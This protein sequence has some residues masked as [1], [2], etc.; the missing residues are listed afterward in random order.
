MKAISLWQ[1]YASLI[2]TGAKKIETRSWNTNVRGTVAIHA[3][4]KKV[5]KEY[6]S[7]FLMSEFQR[8]MRP[9]LDVTHD[10]IRVVPNALPFGAIVGTVEITDCLPIEELYGG[11]YDT[12]N[13]RAFGDWSY[14][15]YGWKLANPVIFKDPLP[16]RGRQGF[17]NWE[18]W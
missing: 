9:Y 6:E 8:G 16:Y 10:N 18:G 11:R 14:G 15:R 13:E 1:P 2:V 7:L 3:A 12:D 5:D 4:K 17:W